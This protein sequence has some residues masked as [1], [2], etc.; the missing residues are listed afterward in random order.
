MSFFDKLLAM[1]RKSSSTSVAPSLSKGKTDA[2]HT[3][4]MAYTE[5][6]FNKKA[7]KINGEHDSVPKPTNVFEPTTC[8]ATIARSAQA[9][10]TIPQ[11]GQKVFTEDKTQAFTLKSPIMT[12]HSSITYAT[13]RKDV[14]AKIYTS[15]ALQIDLFENKARRMVDEKV[16]I[17]GVCWPRA[18]LTNNF[19]DFVGILVPASHGIQLTRSLLRGNEEITR[20]FPKWD[21]RDICLVTHTIIDTICK[22]HKI[23]VRLGSFNPASVYVVSATEVYFVDADNWQIEG[24]PTFSRN[25]TFTPPELLSEPQT[26]RLFTKDEENY[27]MALL[28]FM[29][30]MPGK[31]PYAKKKRSNNYENASNMSFP[32]SLGG[33]M[34]RSSDAERPSGAWQ[35]IWDH[36]PYRMCERFYHTFHGNGNFAQP[37][38]RLNDT[39]WIITVDEYYNSLLLEE[40]AESRELI[41]RTFRRDR[42]RSFEACQ[43]CKQDHPTFYFLHNIYIKRKNERETVNVWDQGYRICLPCAVDKSDASFTCESCKKTYYYN[44]RTKLLHEIGRRD[45]DWD[46]QKWCDYCKQPSTCSRCKTAKP[47][48][49]LKEFSDKRQM[50]TVIACQSCFA[51]LIA[52]DKAWRNKIYMT[53]TCYCGRSFTITNGE[54]ERFLGKGMRLPTRCPLHRG[55]H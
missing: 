20:F 25:I 14:F 27:Q 45:F 21:K 48:Y 53:K 47:R 11:R 7:D 4:P 54:K 29:L 36:L 10:P 3:H 46:K 41:P 23:G 15:N 6:S 12:D 35:I 26:P 43:V 44:N 40:N 1:L 18:I 31:Y 55:R 38:N 16:D 2:K 22:L 52:E 13:N 9:F 33:E 32:F 5:P 49:L 37:G 42:S 39:E 30:M 17:I 24:Y 50:R 28:A 8:M 19:G 51:E 34:R